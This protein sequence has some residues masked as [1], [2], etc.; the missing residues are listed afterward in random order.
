MFA[1]ARTQMRSRDIQ[2]IRCDLNLQRQ[3]K[4]AARERRVVRTEAQPGRLWDSDTNANADLVP[5]VGVFPIW[6]CLREPTHPEF[7]T[8]LVGNRVVLGSAQ[9]ESDV[10]R[11]SQLHSETGQECSLLIPRRVSAHR[12]LA[13]SSLPYCD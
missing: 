9:R 3:D 11:P 12:G 13:T 5:Q 7:R 1:T 10:F 6:L 8:S 4:T 2:S